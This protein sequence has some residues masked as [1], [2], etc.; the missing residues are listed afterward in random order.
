MALYLGNEKVKVNLDQ[1]TLHFNIYSPLMVD[2]IVLL[3]TDNYIL[4]D[5]NGVYLTTKEDE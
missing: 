2:G 4:K 1:H 3:S 5:V